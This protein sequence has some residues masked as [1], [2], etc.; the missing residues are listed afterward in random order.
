MCVPCG[1]RVC[2]I[3]QK[4]DRQKVARIKRVLARDPGPETVKYLAARFAVSVQSITAIRRGETWAWVKP[5]LT[6]QNKGEK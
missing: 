4:L 3:G 5:I 1:R 2:R 6:T